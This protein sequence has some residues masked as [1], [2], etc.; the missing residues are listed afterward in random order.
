MIIDIFGIPG[1]G[2]T[3]YSE[4]LEKEYNKKSFNYLKFERE[5]LAGKALH[6]LITNISIIFPRRKYQYLMKKYSHYGIYNKKRKIKFYLDRIMYLNFL[7]RWFPKK[8]YMILD[9]GLLHTIATM[10]VDFLI[11]DEDIRKVL[12]SIYT[13]MKRQGITPIYHYADVL[14]AEK[15][16]C[17]R[18]RHVCAID[19]LKGKELVLFLERYKHA[20]ELIGEFTNAKVHVREE[21]E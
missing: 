4:V 8:I 10:Q 6:K 1:S 18:N 12:Q 21:K 7:Y 3:Y 15:A 2:K 14:I 20:C 16:I 17:V 19:E 13:T 9:E 11:E 5:T